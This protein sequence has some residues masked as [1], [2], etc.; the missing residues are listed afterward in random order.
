[1]GR[2]KWDY[3]INQPVKWWQEFEGLPQS[4]PSPSTYCPDYEGT[5]MVTVIIPFYYAWLFP[6]KKNVALGAGKLKNWPDKH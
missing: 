1:M 2:E 6:G 4:T 3:E 5:I